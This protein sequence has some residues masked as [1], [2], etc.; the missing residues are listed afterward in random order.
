MLGSWYDTILVGARDA[1][2]A[3]SG[4][5]TPSTET[6][7]RLETDAAIRKAGGDPADVARAQADISAT[8]EP[9]GGTVLPEYG[10]SVLPSVGDIFGNLG[11]TSW[12]L[13]GAGVVVLIVIMK[14]R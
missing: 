5:I 1:I 4:K 3:L 11:M 13:I 2:S 14:D 12:L 7:I 8:L 6:R 10:G 9:Y